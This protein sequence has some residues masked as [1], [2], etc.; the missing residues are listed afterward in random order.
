MHEVLIADPNGV[1]YD[2]SRA[3]LAEPPFIAEVKMTEWHTPAGRSVREFLSDQMALNWWFDEGQDHGFDGHMLYRSWTKKLWAVIISDFVHLTS[4]ASKGSRSK[5]MVM[6]A[7]DLYPLPNGLFT[8]KY[9]DRYIRWVIRIEDT[10]NELLKFERD[11][12]RPPDDGHRAPT[13]LYVKVT[14]KGEEK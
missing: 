14:Q 12:T 2:D 5:I 7:K 11:K 9:I 3:P 4:L 13:P 6:R 1:L 10:M 8:Y